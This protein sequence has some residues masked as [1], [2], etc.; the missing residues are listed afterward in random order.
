M[1]DYVRGLAG[2][3]N[4][5]GA[6]PTTMNVSAILWQGCAMRTSLHNVSECRYGHVRN[7]SASMV[8]LAALIVVTVTAA[9]TSGLLKANSRRRNEGTCEMRSEHP[10]GE[11]V[12]YQV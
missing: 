4:V 10:C 3:T 8:A 7:E 1:D 6:M 9:E 12:C 11:A 2:W 5:S